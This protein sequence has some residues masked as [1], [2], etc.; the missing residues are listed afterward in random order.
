MNLADALEHH[1]RARPDQ[2][3]LVQGERSISHRELRCLVRRAASHL[4]SLRLD[5]GEV[6]GVALRDHLE[7]LVLLYAL[8]RARLVMLPIDWRWTPGERERAARHFGAR[9]TLVEPGAE[10]PG[11]GCIAVDSAWHRAVQQASEDGE[12][13][14]RGDD[15]LLLCLSSGTTGRPKGPMLTHGQFLRRFWTHWIDLG[16]GSRD[17]YLS[18]TP[19]YF[20]G[21]R[22]FCMSV[23]FAGGTVIQF[24]PPWEPQ[25]LV[26]EVERRRATSLFLV[27]TLLR[28]LLALPDSRLAGLASLRLLLSSGSALGAG[29]RREIRARLCANFCEYYASTEGGGISLNTP[30]DQERHPESVGR[31]IFGVEVEIAGEDHR[32]LPHG[33][34]GRLRY[35]GPGCASAFY[36]DAQASA[37][38]FHAG[39]FYPGDLACRDE[40][41]FILLRGRAGDMIIRGGIN[42]YPAEIEAVLMAHPDVTDA[43]VLGVPSTEF[44]EQVAALVCA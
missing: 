25:A 6:V 30:Q 33:Q 40:D 38:A 2:D 22:S 13:E 27:P 36:R 31:A 26:A 44:G 7:H 1:A 10:I 28:R 9:L 8:A 29:E 18:A 21:G 20:G 5:A 42:I 12:F 16:L 43:A 11:I 34:V 37:E 24:P 32:A 35:R 15:P 4:R 17:R 19:V 14:S 23:L 41:G 39:W 3:A